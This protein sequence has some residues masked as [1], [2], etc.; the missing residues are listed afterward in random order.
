MLAARIRVRIPYFPLYSEVRLVLPLWDGCS[1]RDI[2]SLRT[3]IAQLW[4]TPQEPL[5]WSRPDE[6]IPERLSVEHQDLAS[7]IWRGTRR[8]VN[9]RHVQGHWLLASNYGLLEEDADGLM[10]LTVLGSEFVGAPGGEAETLLDER[11]GM[12]KLLSIVSDKGPGRLGAF[13][14]PWGE[15]LKRW[16]KFGTDS[17]IRDTLRRRL[18]NLVDRGLVA[19]SG[20]LY[21]LT[22]GG[23]AY[24]N[25]VGEG[26]GADTT[27]EQEIR[28]LAKQQ[29]ES[30]RD[31]LRELLWVRI[32]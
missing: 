8:K 3:S 32:F 16:S 20:T 2:T 29:Q 21:S 1:R 17:T 14:E 27:Q 23:L 10:R 31:I 6:W 26:E 15:Y 7:A 28:T 9:P 24:L 19:R 5:D 13:V 11:E 18:G 22:D 30:V 12:L 25:R 4:G